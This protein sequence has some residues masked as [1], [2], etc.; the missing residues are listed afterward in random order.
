MSKSLPLL[1]QP[2]ACC[3]PL[4][5]EALSADTA[6]QLAA[7]F[8]AL[9]DPVRL[10]LLSMIASHPGG[11]VCVCDVSTAFA[12]TGPT[13][14]HHL[15]VLRT[16]GLIDAERRGTWVYYWVKPDVLSQLASLLDVSAISAR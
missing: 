15:K 16:A 6:V 9:G 3:P 12:L 13:I 11:E 8:K 14:S 5:T 2:Q 1:D 10:R 4:V 7:G